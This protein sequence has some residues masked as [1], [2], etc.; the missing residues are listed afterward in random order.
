MKR[1]LLT[2]I[3]ALGAAA[4]ALAWP[5]SQD[6]AA[7]APSQL[8]GVYKLKLKGE[9]WI[10]GST[11][12]YRASRVGGAAMLTVTRS[13]AD[14]TKIHVEVRLAPELDGGI[15]D[16]ATPAVAFVG[17]GVLVGDS[18]AVIDTGAATYVNAMTL[19][20]LKDGERVI[21]HWVA[22]YP[23]TDAANGAASGVGVAFTGRRDGR[24]GKP[25][26]TDKPTATPISKAA[27]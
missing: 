6:A 16:L 24:T 25:S 19:T 22:S 12:P 21:G 5:V 14:D 2:A 18:M 3:V 1:L 7:V 10:R 4:G 23:A 13:L 20:F 15:L 27:R 17:D 9:G 8:V 11:E 26:G